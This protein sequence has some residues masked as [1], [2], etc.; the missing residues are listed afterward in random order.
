MFQ[1]SVV[2]GRR[3][4]YCTVFFLV[5]GEGGGLFHSPHLRSMKV[6]CC[7][8]LG[9]NVCVIGGHVTS[10]NQGLSSFSHQRRDE[11]DKGEKA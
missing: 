8:F 4:L 1:E 3:I 10:R 9:E 2:S 5:W 11:G 6:I 7:L